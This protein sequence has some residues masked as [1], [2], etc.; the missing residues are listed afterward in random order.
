[1]DRN[2]SHGENKSLTQPHITFMVKKLMTFVMFWLRNWPKSMW[3]TEGL[4]LDLYHLPLLLQ[5]IHSIRSKV[6]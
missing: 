2:Q 4:K 6:I 3:E 5:L 1:M